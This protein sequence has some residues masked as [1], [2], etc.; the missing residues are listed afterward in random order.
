MAKADPEWKQTFRLGCGVSLED[1]NVIFELQKQFVRFELRERS[2][3]IR[4]L[5]NMFRASK[6]VG[7]VEIAWKDLLASPTLTINNW[8]PLIPIYTIISGGSQLP[9]SLHLAISIKP[10]IKPLILVDSV[11]Q[12]PKECSTEM[13]I[14]DPQV[15]EIRRNRCVR[16][17][18]RSHCRCGGKV[19]CPGIHGEG[20]LSVV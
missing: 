13:G 14:S 12:T 20:V 17:L 15:N 16:S 9:P 18:E 1:C 3:G 19:C 11:S 5:G 2:R 7:W 8:F 6:L 10:S 4:V